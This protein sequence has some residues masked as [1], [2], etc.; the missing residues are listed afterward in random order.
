MKRKAE[1]KSKDNKKGEKE[2]R[3]IA[4]HLGTHI[5]LAA[6]ITVGHLGE[7]DGYR[8]FSSR[9]ECLPQT[10]QSTIL[11]CFIACSTQPY[12]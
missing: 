11:R 10:C 3:N 12:A 6:C 2:K 4:L 8:T 5:R 7:I 1:K 9:D